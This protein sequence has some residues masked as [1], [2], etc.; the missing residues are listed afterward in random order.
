MVRY[1]TQYVV[2]VRSLPVLGGSTAI[3]LP[4]LVLVIFLG[5]HGQADVQVRLD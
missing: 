4:V 3:S 5:S 1:S 2:L